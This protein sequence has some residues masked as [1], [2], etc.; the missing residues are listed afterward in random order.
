M[1]LVALLGL[2]T[3]AILGSSF[4]AA[5]ADDPVQR[6]LYVVSPDAAGGRGGKGIY[7]FD[8]DNGHKL[9]RK[10]DLPLKGV[11]GVCG[12]AV[13]GRLWIS[14][15]DTTITCLDLKTDKVLWDK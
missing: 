4:P 11:R 10:I 14:H 6:L 15:G 12:S 9:V 3:A 13:T 8:I 7:I 2:L 1:R 5:A